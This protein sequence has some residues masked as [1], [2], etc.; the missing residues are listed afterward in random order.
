MIKFSSSIKPV[1][2]NFVLRRV[3]FLISGSLKKLE[4]GF[5]KCCII[6]SRST[7]PSSERTQTPSQTRTLHPLAT[8]AASTQTAWNERSLT[9]FC[10]SGSRSRRSLTQTRFL[11]FCIFQFCLALIR[12]SSFGSFK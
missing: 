6:F 4:S 9:H 10:V 7:W 3:C 5:N 12:R 2:S 11:Y 8:F 1:Y